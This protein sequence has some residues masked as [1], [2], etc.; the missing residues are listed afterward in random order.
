[1][2][3]KY[4]VHLILDEV[5]SGFGRTGRMFASEHA[6]VSPDFMCVSKGIT[7]G[8]LPLGVTITTDDVYSA[9][10][11]DYESNKTFFHGH[12]YTA[13]P[14]S[15]AAA[16]ASIDLFGTENTLE[17]VSAINAA[18]NAFLRDVKDHPLVG[19]TRSIGAVGAIEL[20]KDKERKEPF[21]MKERIGLE[22]YKAGLERNILLRPLGN[23][24]YF[25]LPLCTRKEELNGIFE[26]ASSVLCGAVKVR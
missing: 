18:L 26:A 24:I 6:G 19:D 22:F 21:G 12:T 16:C 8:Y 13:N 3:E 2:A 14:I 1:L 10:Y 7:S 17:N 20:V 5:A 9:F 11:D 15:C 25:F 4:G 23:V